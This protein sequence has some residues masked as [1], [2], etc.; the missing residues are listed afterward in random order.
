MKKF[1]LLTLLSLLLPIVANAYDAKINGIYYNFHGDEAEVTCKKDFEK[2]YSGTVVIPE[3]VTYNG[4]TYSVTSIGDYAFLGSII[5][6][7]HSLKSVT[8]P[9]SVTSIGRLAFKGCGGLTSITIPNSVTSIGEDAF[10][11]CSGLTSITIPNSVTSIGNG[12]FSGCFS[13]TSITIPNSVTSIGA[14]AFHGC[15]RLTSITIP[16]SV[17]S[18]DSYTFNCCSSL[19]S[20]TIPE[21]V[22]KIGE[23]SFENCSSLTSVTI[24]GNITY[25]GKNIFKDCY[26]LK[27]VTVSSATSDVTKLGLSP[28]VDI[29]RIGSS[30]LASVPTINNAGASTPAPATTPKPATTPAPTT[31]P[32]PATTPKPTTTPKPATTPA[33]TTTPK[34]TTT[35]DADVDKNLPTTSKKQERT[36]ALIIANEH[37]EMA[38][39][40]AYALNDGKIFAD[41]CEQTLGLPKH[42]I[43][44]YEDATFGKMK[45]AM[46]DIK[47]IADAY[48][49]DM[50]LI[51]Y[52]A[53]HGVPN[54]QNKEAYLL[55]VDVDGRHTEE[56]CY[57]LSKFYKELGELKSKSVTVFLDA[58]FSGAQR[59][60]GMLA[61]VRGVAIKPKD[62]TPQGNMVVFSAATG[63]ETASPYNEKGH[64]LFTYFL[65][66]K[67]RESKGDCTL[68]ELGEYVQK[69]VR[70]Q[71]VVINRKSQTPTIVPSQ[72]L[73]N[74][75]QTLKLK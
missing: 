30:D 24:L 18:I 33:T 9:N 61:S 40:V 45:A 36:F 19:T 67:L 27:T 3:S 65:L 28:E 41:Y 29:V 6:A 46:R 70:Q 38:E 20:V 56:D 52:Y 25:C 32:K 62:N 64:G 53:G 15:H 60:E 11:S 49:G 44:F 57:P 16:N 13:L 72:S 42:N 37:Y 12:A 50:Q 31:T 17:T 14:S 23:E 10:S 21:S 63:D 1:F 34:P 8:I 2:S 71:S 35:P 5:F 4:K 43:R 73:K 58:C 75:W 74:S 69:S 59:G 68:G 7:N 22:T 26:K 54:E 66:K 39:P 48:E 47:E 55:P 51:V